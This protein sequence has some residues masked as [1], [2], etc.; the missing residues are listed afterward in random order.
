MN[1][2]IDEVNEVV[3][4]EMELNFTTKRG[5]KMRQVEVSVQHWNDGWIEKEKFYY[6]DMS[7]LS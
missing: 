3:F 4:T 7:N 2:A 1:Q 6:K 5:R